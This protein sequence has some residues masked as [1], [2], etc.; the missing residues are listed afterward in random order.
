M[1]R[2]ES[3]GQAD[4]LQELGDTLN[5][6]STSITEDLM[7]P[8][9]RSAQDPIRFLPRLDNQWLELYG[10]ITGTDG[11]IYGGA[12]GA[13]H[14][15]TTERLSVLNLEGG[16]CHFTLSGAVRKEFSVSTNPSNGLDFPQ[17][18]YQDEGRLVS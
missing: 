9:N 7:Q 6:K 11:Y 12:E 18:F 17:L 16:C 13:P 2:A 15:G 14:E 3:V 10:R 5:N 8:N 1:D 4:V